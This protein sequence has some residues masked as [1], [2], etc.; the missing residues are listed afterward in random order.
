MYG[1][2]VLCLNIIHD[3]PRE[4]WAVII[5]TT[6]DVRIGYCNEE[7]NLDPDQPNC[8]MYP[9]GEVELEDEGYL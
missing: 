9:D 2:A 1:N 8:I 5:L 4:T 7:G 6:G 3:V